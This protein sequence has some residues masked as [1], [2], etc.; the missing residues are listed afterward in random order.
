IT[1][2]FGAVTVV[3]AVIFLGERLTLAETIAVVIAGGGSLLAAVEFRGLKQVRLIGYGPLAALA[4]VVLGSAIT[5]LL[6]DPI[7]ANGWVPTVIAERTG[8]ALAA[9]LGLLLV[10]SGAW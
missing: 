3:F 8:V 4:A 2:M 10:N 1:A 9:G 6:Q 7:R 5:V